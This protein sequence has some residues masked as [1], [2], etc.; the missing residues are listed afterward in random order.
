[1]KQSEALLI[2]GKSRNAF[3]KQSK[4]ILKAQHNLLLVQ[5]LIKSTYV[6]GVNIGKDKVYLAID[7][8]LKTLK[9][10]MGRDKIRRIIDE[11][12]FMPKANKKFRAKS[13]PTK[14]TKR[15]YK[16]LRE[17]L[18]VTRPNQLW[19]TDITMHP[20][21]DGYI[22]H[23]VIQDSYSRA[24]LGSSISYSLDTR[25]TIIA[26]MQQ[27]E[28]YGIPE[29]IHSDRGTQFTSSEWE[30]YASQNNILLSYSKVG[31]PYDNANIERFFN[32]LKNEL[33]LRSKDDETLEEFAQRAKALIEYY[34]NERI[35][36]ALNFRTPKEIYFG[37]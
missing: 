10:K 7:G 33:E 27:A 32:T 6:K 23:C 25:S 19:F 24:I 2:A 5:K 21:K 34:N 18:E 16:N 8:Y 20:Y 4:K 3:S 12:G 13:K 9:I 31:Y 22:V 15:E 28:I 26:A 17:G 1:M 11:Y 35:H 30:S 29:I 37:F 14:A 36:Q